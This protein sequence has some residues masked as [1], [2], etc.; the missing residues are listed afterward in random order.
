MTLA[1]IVVGL[2][3]GC[4]GSDSNPAPSPSPTPSPTPNPPPAGTVSI[5]SGASSLGDRA[6][7][8][9]PIMITAGTTVTW[10]NNDTVTHTSTGDGG[11]F[12]SGAMAPG[13]TFKFTFPAAG[14]FQYH[15]TI[16]PGMVGSVVVQ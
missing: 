15:C 7:N 5:I 10:T 13:A 12:D 3:L 1:L 11:A 4:G 2:T 8:P 16:H 9:N 6:Y 14:T